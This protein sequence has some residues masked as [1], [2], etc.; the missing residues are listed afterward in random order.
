[1]LCTAVILVARLPQ[2]VIIDRAR[3]SRLAPDVRFAPRATLLLR[4]SEMSRWAKSGSRPC[5]TSG[6]ERRI[7][8]L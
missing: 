7:S 3:Q 4:S 8:N 6:G 5:P 2:G 1:M